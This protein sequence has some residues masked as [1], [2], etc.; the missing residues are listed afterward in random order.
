MIK[1]Y[2][3]YSLASLV[4]AF[5]SEY[6]LSSWPE[7][8]APVGSRETHISRVNLAGPDMTEATVS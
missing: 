6:F 3:F 4:C 5:S 2:L 7:V 1:T 8:G